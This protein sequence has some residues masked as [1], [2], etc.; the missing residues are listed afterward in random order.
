MELRSSGMKHFDDKCMN[1]S[2]SCQDALV[3]ISRRQFCFALLGF[4]FI[5]M[6]VF[7]LSCFVVLHVGK[8]KRLYTCFSSSDNPNL[9]VVQYGLL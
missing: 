2:S 5:L 9:P 8:G 1:S 3:E 4:L 7:D 6:M